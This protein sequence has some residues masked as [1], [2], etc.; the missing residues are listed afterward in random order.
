MSQKKKMLFS[1]L[2]KKKDMMKAGK[3]LT[4]KQESN[5]KNIKKLNLPISPNTKKENFYTIG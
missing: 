4:K 2:S 5:L 3:L 1:N